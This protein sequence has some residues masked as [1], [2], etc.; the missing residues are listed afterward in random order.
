MRRR[1]DQAGRQ[2]V[3]GGVVKH[4]LHGVRTVFDALSGLN[5][6]D[7]GVPRETRVRTL[8]RRADE[9]PGVDV[10]QRQNFRGGDR[11]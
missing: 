10:G 7:D 2:C 9:L 1:P 4:I 5:V 3:A 11:Y 6:E 8:R